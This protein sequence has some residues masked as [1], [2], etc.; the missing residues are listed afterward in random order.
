MSP[1]ALWRDT[2]L[3]ALQILIDEL[4]AIEAGQLQRAAQAASFPYLE[5]RDRRAM[6]GDWERL[7][8]PQGAPDPNAFSPEIFED[9]DAAQAYFERLG[10]PVKR[11]T[12]A[13]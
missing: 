13:A 7:T 8:R 4:P 9:L 5:R 12:E 2:P 1:G 3:W 11:I 6:A 10:I